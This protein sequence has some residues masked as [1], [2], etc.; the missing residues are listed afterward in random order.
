MNA[1]RLEAALQFSLTGLNRTNDLLNSFH[2]YTR[3]TDIVVS[4]RSKFP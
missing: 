1:L 2:F 4:T 3:K